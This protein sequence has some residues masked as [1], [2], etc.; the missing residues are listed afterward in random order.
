VKAK[1]QTHTNGYLKYKP[2]M[3]TVERL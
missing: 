2:A 3:K 1:Q